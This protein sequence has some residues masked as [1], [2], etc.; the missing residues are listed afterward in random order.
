VRPVLNTESRK[1]IPSL[2]KD[3][4]AIAGITENVVMLQTGAMNTGVTL[5]RAQ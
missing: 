4:S 5:K 2:N 3:K 1:N